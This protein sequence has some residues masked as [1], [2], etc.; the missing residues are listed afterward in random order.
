M[1]SSRYLAIILLLGFSTATFAQKGGGGGGG[2]NTGGGGKTST[3]PAVTPTLPSSTTN[4]PVDIQPQVMYL[5][6][7]VV[8]AQGGAPPEPAAIER[9]C[10]G[11][12]HK[13]GYTDSKGRYQIQLGQNFEIQDVSETAGNSGQFGLGGR[14]QTS[15]G[16]PMGGISARDL[17][18][19]ELRAVLSG[20]Q[21]SSV[22]IRVD[23]AFGEVRMDTI[24]LQPLG[25][26]TGSTISLTSMQAPGSARKAYEKA[27]RDVDKN[28]L[29]DAEKEL[30]KAV[31][32]Y[33]KY[34]AAWALL[35]AVHQQFNQ[36]DEALK[37]YDQSI[38]ADP[39]Y[40]KPYFG[41]TLIAAGKKNWKDTV[42]FAD[43][44]DRLAPSAYPEAYFF[45]GVANYNLN[46]LDDAEKSLRKFL[47]LDVNHVR[48]VAALYLGDILVRKQDYAGAAQQAR[49]YLA[50]APNASN[51]NDV[52]EKLKQMEQMSG[53]AQKQ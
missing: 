11:Y 43:Q 16:N 8:M 2:G 51:A 29:K 14:S 30:T 19:C 39:Q 34:A 21:S 3:G 48:P 33:P 20:F 50:L 49:D 7:T 26:G 9:V 38:A 17:M 6:G 27:E 47:K 32:Q 40:A 23:G 42:R 45:N 18:G 28:D 25:G 12:A 37:D 46:N 4:M 15:L 41:L 36:I 35:G 24:V 31:G 53:T 13:E 5:S 44:L 1:F 52:R 10:G 22:M